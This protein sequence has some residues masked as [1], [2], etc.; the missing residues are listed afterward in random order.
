MYLKHFGFN[1]F[2]FALTPNLRFFCNLAAYKEAMN[3]IMV[4]LHNNEGFVKITGEVGTGKTLL[5]RKLLSSLGDEYVTAYIS[6]GSLDTFNLQ[7]ACA[8]ELGISFRENIDNHTLLTLLNNKLISLHRDSKRVVLVI[9]EAHA[10]SDQTLEGLRFLSNLETES[11]KLLQIVLVGQ[12]ELDRRLN[13][14]HLRQLKHR[15]IFSYR[16]PTLRNK[17]ELLS[18]ICHRLAYAGYNNTYD[19]L[20]SPKAIRLLLKASRGIPRLVNVICHKSLLI[21][22]GYDKKKISASTIKIA[23]ADT[24]SVATTAVAYMYNAAKIAAVSL[25]LTTTVGVGIYFILRAL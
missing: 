14:Q 9:D 22:Y 3:I 7:K 6:N 11:S 25:L 21:A 1:E 8:H 20:F 23:I 17:K 2:P 10:L 13:K 24:D 19:S 15:I 5:C 16:L 4:S 18:Y 12:P